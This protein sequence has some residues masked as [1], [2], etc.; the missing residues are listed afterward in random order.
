MKYIRKHYK[1]PAK[2]GGRVR[3]SGDPSGVTHDGTI[4]SAKD[5]RIRVRF[6]GNP[7][8]RGPHP[9][10]C[11]PTWKIEYLPATEKP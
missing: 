9:I 11:H 1:V 2:R 4:T 3:Y 6:D 7:F 5:A 10:P 8:G